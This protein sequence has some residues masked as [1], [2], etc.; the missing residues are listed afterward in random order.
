MKTFML[1]LLFLPFVLLGEWIDPPARSKKGYL[2]PTPD[3]KP[4]FPRDH[5]S[6]REYGIE[7]WYWVGHLKEK[8]GEREF[9]F[10]STVF[11]LAGDPKEA[12]KP[13]DGNFGNR[14]LYLAHS[15]LSDLGQGTY[16]HHERILRE[17]WQAKASSRDL[18]LKVAGIE[19]RM[20][21]D[22]S[23]HQVV[24]RLPGD[25]K[26]ELV[27][28]PLKPL[29]TFG[30]RGLSRK[31]A[32]PAAV[33]WYWTYPRLEA[34]GRL[35]YQGVEIEVEGTVWMDHEVSSSQL[36]KDLAGWD[37]TCVHLDD[38]TELKAY[39]LR[40]NDGGSDPWSAVY[41]IDKEGRA[42][43]IYA[44]DFTWNEERRWTS[45]DTG[46]S[47]PTS[48]RIE[49]NHPSRGKLVYRLRP[50]IENQEF[51]GNGKGNDYWEGACEAL[52]GKGKK[53]GKAYLELAGY[54]G[55]LGARLN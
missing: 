8:G 31:G 7:W 13:A 42:T 9:G 46:L 3:Y 55:S 11:R 44:K 5:G 32:D 19:V 34:K 12:V 50:L 41:W 33:S 43:R 49:A 24:S 27:M 52:D 28:R 39:R 16:L 2:V 20:L 35:R 45:P 10:Q 53:I 40:K 54:G 48:V 51:S 30:E 22:G 25:G 47:Y 38:G 37:W 18:D 17:G 26:L 6:H 36:G 29:V 14:Q 1:W 15:A 21:E 23:G 4:V